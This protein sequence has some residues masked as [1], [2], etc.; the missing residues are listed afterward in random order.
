VTAPTRVVL[1]CDTANEIDDQFA[2]AH[3]L[4]SPAL[5]VLGVVS[6]HDTV[7]H[8][9]VSRDLYHNEAL[10]VVGLCGRSA[11]VPCLRG[12]DRPLED[13]RTAVPS[14][15]LDFIAA[16]AET[17]P[18]TILAT[19]PATDLASLALTAPHLL[20]RVTVIWAGGF[21]D[22]ATWQRKKFG[23]LNARAD[24]AAWRRLFLDPVPLRVLPGWPGVETVAVPWR[25]CV[26][27]LQELHR[28][29]TDYLAQIVQQ[30]AAHRGVNLD[31]DD[32]RDDD[33]KVLWD[34]V[35]V[36]ALTRPDAVTFTPTRLPDIDPAGVP[37]WT[38][39]GRVAEIGLDIDAAAVLDDLW[40][41][42]A[43]LPERAA[44]PSA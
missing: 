33:R 25:A 28:P 10:R 15:G 43:R 27:R 20:D 31:M 32:D 21:P 5:D 34:I 12:A 14:E 26:G 17:E 39:P 24:I 2:I 35:N 7:A 8:G 41:A 30:Y 36:A 3:A 44:V 16:T 37:D 13:T 40:A 11:D 6:V 42:L 38:R 9:R 4:G 29:A 1:D 19:G 22:D 23:E 18:V